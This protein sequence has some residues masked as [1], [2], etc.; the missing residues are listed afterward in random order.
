MPN[1]RLNITWAA[2][3]AI[4][5]LG[6]C[7]EAYV[8]SQPAINTLRLCNRYGSGENAAIN[9]L[10]V[11]LVEHIEGYY[12]ADRRS[13]LLA[14]W[15]LELACW[16]ATCSPLEHLDDED[17]IENIMEEYKCNIDLECYMENNDEE[18]MGMLEEHLIE[19]RDIGPEPLPPY[20]GEDS[21]RTVHVARKLSWEKKTGSPGHREVSQLDMY[22]TVLKKHFGLEVWTSHVQNKVQYPNR[23]DD[24][25]VGRHTVG[26]LCL[27]G[28]H[29]SDHDLKL[30][31]KTFDDLEYMDTMQIPSEHMSA[32]VFMRGKDA[33]SLPAARFIH[34][35]KVL[36]LKPTKG[37]LRE[38][39]PASMPA[40]SPGKEKTAEV[41]LWPRV[42]VLA[43]QGRSFSEC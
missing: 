36:N 34:A 17:E 38:D 1:L 16:K 10:P 6:A 24:T 12:M 14:E 25:P 7:V 21:W 43:S 13:Q 5:K 22:N 40:Q 29:S 2:P 28:G 23:W 33:I 39:K 4:D 15:K 8:T 26:Y 3:V 37:R 9:K 18:N 11:E 19:E 41:P 42:L 30:E 32:H 20:T 27:A 35:M 31:E